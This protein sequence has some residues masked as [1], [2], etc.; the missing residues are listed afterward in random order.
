MRGENRVLREQLGT[1]QLRFTDNQRR[2]WAAK[3]KLVDPSCR[4]GYAGHIAGRRRS[5]RRGRGRPRIAGEI[6]KLVVGMAPEI[7]IGDTG[8]FSAGQQRYV[9]LFF[10]ELSTCRFR[11]PES[12]V[13]RTVCGRTKSHG[14]SATPSTNSSKGNATS[15]MIG[16]LC[17]REVSEHHADAAVKSVK[18]PPRSPNPNACTE[19]LFGP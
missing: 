12:R 2:R 7:V 6:E 13:W 16:T 17:Y 9:V 5:A 11:L 18:L 3:A 14:T 8:G 1:H 19:R 4:S 15:S 10:L